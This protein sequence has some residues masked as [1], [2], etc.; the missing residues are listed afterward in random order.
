[1]GFIIWWARAW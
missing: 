1:M